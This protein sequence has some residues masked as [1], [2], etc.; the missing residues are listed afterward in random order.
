CRHVREAVDYVMWI[1]KPEIQRATY[2]DAGGQPGSR[3]AWL[4]VQ[5]NKESNNFFLDTWESMLTAYVRPRH[6]GFTQLQGE[7]G[8]IISE[9]LR[10][11][12]RPRNV[13]QKLDKLFLGAGTRKRVSR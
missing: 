2:F 9:G 11:H 1:T 4:D 5:V 7:G 12:R 10:E 8:T 6:F 13:L 3:V